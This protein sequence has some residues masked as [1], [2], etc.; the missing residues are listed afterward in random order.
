VKVVHGRETPEAHGVIVIAV[1]AEDGQADVHVRVGVVDV[2]IRVVA[3]A[4]IDGRVADEVE[5]DGP[6]SEN[7][8]AQDG[9]ALLLGEPGRL[10]L[11]VQVAAEQ[12]HVD[13][14]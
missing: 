2:A 4:E 14:W 3:V 12:D 5:G 6:V 9:D 10:V 7:V 11:V 13:V 8:L 1:D